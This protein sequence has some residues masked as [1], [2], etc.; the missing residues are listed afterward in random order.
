MSSW[1]QVQEKLK[2]C[3]WVTCYS[4]YTVF[5]PSEKRV[6]LHFIP[7][8]VC[9][10]HNPLT[11]GSTLQSR[12]Q[13]QCRWVL[14]DAAQVSWESRWPYRSHQEGQSPTQAPQ[15]NPSFCLSTPA[16]RTLPS[17]E[18]PLP[19]NLSSKCCSLQLTLS[20]QTSSLNC[21]NCIRL[22]KPWESFPRQKSRS[23]RG[24]SGCINV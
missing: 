10:S 18:Y 14:L 3:M 13:W 4:Y 15:P 11:S 7:S 23:I 6:R 5:H 17:W 16:P 8:D 2:L 19:Y 21:I 22:G 24:N 12:H 20:K 9:T 1:E